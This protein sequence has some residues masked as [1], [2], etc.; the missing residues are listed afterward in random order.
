MDR[1]GAFPKISAYVFTVQ[2]E[3]WRLEDQQAIGVRTIDLEFV[4]CN[5]R[6][7]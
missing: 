2:V 7:W 1:H 4:M 3:R 6:S 5:R